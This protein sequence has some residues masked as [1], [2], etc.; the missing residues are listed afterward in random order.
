MKW[1]ICE[2]ILWSHSWSRFDRHQIGWCGLAGKR[3]K[4]IAQSRRG[5]CTDMISPPTWK[6]SDPPR[7]PVTRPYS[8]ILSTRTRQIR[9]RELVRSTGTG[10]KGKAAQV[11]KVAMKRPQT[12]QPRRRP[13]AVLQQ[14]NKPTKAKQAT[15]KKG[16]RRP[17]TGPLER[18]AKPLVQ[19][20]K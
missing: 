5:S 17:R 20:S 1:H 2:S 4:I 18:T 7:R 12:A 3:E 6:S 9:A 15:W 13:L 19:E 8:A 16:Y 10:R 14:R 11:Y